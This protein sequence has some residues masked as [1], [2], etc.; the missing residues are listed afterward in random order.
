MKR[1]RLLFIVNRIVLSGAN[2]PLLAHL[3]SKTTRLLPKLHGYWKNYLFIKN[4]ELTVCN[5]HAVYVC[6]MFVEHTAKSTF[7]SFICFVQ[8]S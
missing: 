6:S 3:L 1:G 8:G 2:L 7:Q 5:D 4:I